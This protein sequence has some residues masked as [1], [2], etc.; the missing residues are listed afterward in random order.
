MNHQN[1]KKQD[2]QIKLINQHEYKYLDH[3]CTWLRILGWGRSFT[4][5]IM[6]DPVKYKQHEN[7]ESKYQENPENSNE[8]F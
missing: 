4:P 6:N 8:H 5:A 1:L 2:N 3:L 7:N